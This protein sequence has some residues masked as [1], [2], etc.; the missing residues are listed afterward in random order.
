MYPPVE[1]DVH[2]LLD[3]GEG[4]LL[5]WEACGDAGAAPALVLHGGP[6][7][8]CTP[9]QR[10]MFD[11]RRHRVVLV[12]QR[13][14]GRSRP[15]AADPGTDLGANTTG[16]LV[17]D[18]ERLRTHLGI[19][20]WLVYGASW[21]STL[22]LAYAQAHPRSVRRMVLCGVTMTRRREVDWLFGGVGRFLPEAWER[23]CGA[24]P[25]AAGDGGVV[26]AYA[27]RMEDADP[28]VRDAAARA[29]TDWE[30]AVVAHEDRG[31]PRAY[32]GRPDRDRSAF[33]RICTRYFANAAWLEEGA[34]LAGAP[35][36]AGIPGVLV[37]GRLDLGS[38][39][40][41]AWQLRRAWPDARL[42]VVDDAG[43]TGSPAMRA[44]VLAALN[45]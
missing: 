24:V 18:I 8:G 17:A 37:H 30:D 15:H 5:Y 19:D 3:V 34:L 43:H 32:S 20:R 21:G 9:G 14:C 41:S 16:R 27:A 6:G 40:E 23:F 39:L 26:A 42:V 33:V 13:N 2:G 45:G 28:A 38:P 22:A 35:R 7:S 4:N 25:E 10:R 31:D 29:W 44:R 11:P 12:D 36:L 1:P